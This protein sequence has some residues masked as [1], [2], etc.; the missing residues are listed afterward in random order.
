M[1]RIEK[2]KAKDE[3]KVIFNNGVF[4]NIDF[5][6]ITLLLSY[7]LTFLRL[8]R[9]AYCLLLTAY[10]LLLLLSHPLTVSPSHRLTNIRTLSYRD[11]V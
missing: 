1:I 8:L 2:A 3:A 6:F 11:N 7:S 9:T 5:N 4:I 10:C